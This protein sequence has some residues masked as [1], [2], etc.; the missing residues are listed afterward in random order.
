MLR[1]TTDGIKKTINP[2]LH[3]CVVREPCTDF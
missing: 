1:L 3:T 2:I